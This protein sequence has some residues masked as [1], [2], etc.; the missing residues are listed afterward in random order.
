MGPTNALSC[1]NNIDILSNNHSSFIVPDSVIINT[2][3][4]ALSKSISASTPSDP[5]VIR[6]L[7]A[8]QDSSPLF[9]CSFL[10]DWTYDNRHLY[11]KGCMY[12]P[13]SAHSSLL[14]LIH[15]S[16]TMD[17]MGIFCTKSILKQ[18]FWWPS[19]SSF[20]KHFVDSC[21]I[22]QQSK[23]NTH[24]TIPSLTSITSSTVLL[25]KQ[26]SIDLIT[27]LSPS[28]GHDSIVVIVDHS[29]MKGVILTPCSKTIDVAGIAQ[30]FLDNVFKHFS[31]HNTLI[32]NHGPQFASIFAQ[33]LA[34]LLKY[35][36]W[37][38][39]A[40]HLQTDGQTEQ[41]NQELE[42]YL[43][44]FYTNSPSSWFQF[45]S[46]VEFHHNSTPHS[47]TKRSPFSL[48]YGYEPRSYPPL[49]KTFLLAL[50]NCLSILD[51]ARKEAL[52]TH[53]STQK[54]MASRTTC[55]FTPWKV[56]DKVWLKATHFHL[57]Y[58][59]RKL[60][61][62]HHGPFK[63]TCILSPLMYQLQLP[64][65]WKIHNIFHALL[66]L[67]YCSTKPHG[68][69]FLNPPP[70]IIDNEE[71]YEVEAILSHKGPKSQ[72]LYLITWKGYSSAKSTW[73][74]ESNL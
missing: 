10:S 54:I 16:P 42:T 15:S 43:W 22:C 5:L 4:L 52:T 28:D 2:L 61:P 23:V 41:I 40:Y 20:I 38:S 71:E 21:T 65:T 59:S 45:L 19:L 73:E 18:D 72:W 39:T 51:K 29:L 11:F 48:L 37:L 66:L 53:E 9:S 32:S 67:S 33:E 70:D 46:I 63:I 35:D 57:H 49:S 26:L 27:D 3:D 62:K 1:K 47:F 69:T 60:A 30:I 14:H 13:P 58:P 50:K 8:L 31:L 64:K 6:V 55:R 25:F 24:P 36:V 17:Y 68:P 74:P 44:I 34:H 12:V 56:G 7:S